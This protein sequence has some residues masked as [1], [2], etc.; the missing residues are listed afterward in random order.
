[1]ISVEW[2]VFKQRMRI[3][4]ENLFFPIKR[5]YKIKK[6]LFFFW[7]KYHNYSDELQYE[8]LERYVR[9][10]NYQK[11]QEESYGRFVARKIAEA[12]ENIG[13]KQH[14]LRDIL[15]RILEK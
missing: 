12:S 4:I 15:D 9:L 13:I 1:M 7:I 10:Y 5:Q 6:F 14:E 8:I 11:S 2:F 3:K